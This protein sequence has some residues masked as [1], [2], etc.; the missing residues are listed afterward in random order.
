MGR[1]LTTVAW[2]TSGHT[3]GFALNMLA[4]HP[5]EQEML[6]KHIQDVLP[7]GRLPVSVKQLPIEVPSIISFQAYED[8]SRLS[9]VTAYVSAGVIWV[10][11]ASTEFRLHSTLYETLRMF[12]PVSCGYGSWVATNDRCDSPG[13]CHPKV[14]RGGHPCCCWER[15]WKDDCVPVPCWMRDQHRY[16]R[17][18]L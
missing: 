6:H 4:V 18:P 8:I 14:Y 17:A 13:T 7:D 5:E 9:R 2:Q 11:A 16:R 12:P 15:S 10:P 1:V 3:L